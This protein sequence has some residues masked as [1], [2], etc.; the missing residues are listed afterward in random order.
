M[1]DNGCTQI[2]PARFL[3]LPRAELRDYWGQVPRGKDDIQQHL[4]LQFWGVDG[5]DHCGDARS[6]DG[7]DAGYDGQQWG[8]ERLAAS[9]NSDPGVR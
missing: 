6:A 9:T 7:A 5:E 4:P 1:K 8:S 2:H 3:A